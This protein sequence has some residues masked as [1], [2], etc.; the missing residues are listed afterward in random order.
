MVKA[1][2]GEY[3]E[4]KFRI[5]SLGFYFGTIVWNTSQ[6]IAC[7]GSYLEFT[8]DIRWHKCFKFKL[9]S[10]GNK[11]LFWDKSNFK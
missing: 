3:R 4:L 1:P 9:L 5:F 7:D 11:H 2:S 8:K 6:A 10:T